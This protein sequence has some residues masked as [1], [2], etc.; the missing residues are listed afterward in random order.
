MQEKASL[1]A[2]QM[3]L[4]AAL[5][6]GA[7]IVDAAK[8]C[9]INECTAHRWLKQPAITT[10]LEEGK[11]RAF[12]DALGVLRTGVKAAI[13]TLAS[14]MRAESEGVRLRAAQ[15]WLTTAVE[16]HKMSEIEQRF[17]ELEQLLKAAG[18]PAKAQLIEPM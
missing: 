11:Q 18:L 2:K 7:S 14:S 12:S 3:Q 9:K 10:A 15:I 8:A 17:D 6:G 1:N 16:L 4:I 5:V 13:T